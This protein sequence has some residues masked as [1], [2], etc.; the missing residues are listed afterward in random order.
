MSE[1]VEITG[2]QFDVANPDRH[3]NVAAFVQELEF[4][5]ALDS[6]Y[7]GV[8]TRDNID[9]DFGYVVLAPDQNASKRAIR[10]GAALDTQ[11]EAREKLLTEMERL[12]AGGKQ[13]HP[14]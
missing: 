6:W 1:V 10:F 4:Y 7:I 11:D 9:K 14:Q 5:S 13:V 2:D 3:P 8:V 12:A